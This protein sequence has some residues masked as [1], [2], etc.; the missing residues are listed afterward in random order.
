MGRGADRRTG[1]RQK[2]EG[3]DGQKGEGAHGLRG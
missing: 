3:A 2:G 1:G